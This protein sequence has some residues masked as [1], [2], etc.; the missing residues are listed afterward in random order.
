MVYNKLIPGRGFGAINT[1]NPPGVTCGEV[2][3]VILSQLFGAK[4]FG[5]C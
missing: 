4:G 2:T 1:A 5:Q 3:M